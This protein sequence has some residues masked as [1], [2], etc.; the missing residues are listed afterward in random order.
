MNATALVR[1]PRSRFATVRYWRPSLRLSVGMIAV[2]I[3]VAMAF[4]LAEIVAD[5][6]RRTAAA[7]AVHNV[8]AIVRGFVDPEVDD[9]S[10][11]LDASPQPRISAELDRLIVAGD[12][13]VISIWSRDGRVVYST[14]PDV[15][16]RRFSIDDLVATAFSGTSAS[17]YS[18]PGQH[19]DHR[20]TFADARDMLDIYVPIRGAVD[21]NPIGVYMV[22]QDARSITE[23]VETTRRD[24]FVIALATA[25][26]LFVE[27]AF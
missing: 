5:Q 13:R 19:V 6:L 25:S 15:H 10:L 11:A 9:R 21:G 14:E 3:V 23:R 22:A 24:V 16:G 12:I 7:A 8:E 20:G 26:A 18:V 4:V 2:A 27:N 17:A 1:T